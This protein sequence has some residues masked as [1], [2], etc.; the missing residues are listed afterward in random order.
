MIS[1]MRMVR[2][3]FEDFFTVGVISSHAGHPLSSRGCD[4][5]TVASTEIDGR[6]ARTQRTRE[7]IIDAVVDLLR[8]DVVEPSASQIAARAGISKRSIFVHYDSLD[9]LNVDLAQRS[10]AMVLERVWAIDPTLPLADR[11]G[12][13]CKQR[14]DIHEV[15]GP[16]R[17][18]AARRAATSDIAAE[19]Q[20]YSRQA[21]REQLERV[22]AA[23]LAPLTPVKRRRRIAAVDAVISG[24]T[25][26][27]WR[28][29]DAMTK[30]EAR[31]CMRDA[32]TTLLA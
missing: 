26:D 28:R 2:L 11:I 30:N 4:V 6:L 19:S 12:A 20:R 7:A 25:W 15:I 29:H 22:F 23:E 13:L 8:E 32:V 14:A 9:A 24:E 27:A 1:L 31:A 16:L 5:S 17:R 3:A 10:T 21:S 18:A